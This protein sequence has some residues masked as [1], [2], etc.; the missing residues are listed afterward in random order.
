M[1][2]DNI[3]IHKDYVNSCWYLQTDEFG[4]I[5]IPF[6]S[7]CTDFIKQCY[8]VAK[9]VLDL[10]TYNYNIY[11]YVTKHLDTA[12][13]TYYRFTLHD[14][15][16]HNITEKLNINCQSAI[17]E[18]YVE[19]TDKLTYNPYRIELHKNTTPQYNYYALCF[20]SYRYW[21]KLYKHDDDVFDKLL[22]PTFRPCYLL[23]TTP[24][25][26]TAIHKVYS[27]LSELTAT[28]VKFIGSTNINKKP[29]ETYQI[30]HLLF[31]IPMDYHAA[32]ESKIINDYRVCKQCNHLFK[33]EHSKQ[34]FCKPCSSVPGFANSHRPER[35]LIEKRKYAIKRI[36][37]DIEEEYYQKDLPSFIDD[38]KKHLQEL[39]KKLKSE[40]LSEEDIK[41]IVQT[42]DTW[43]RGQL[44]N[45]YKIPEVHKQLLQQ[46]HNK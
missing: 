27:T 15:E 11:N 35:I 34:V 17:K 7:L 32:I 23:N 37:E 10:I 12:N 9:S 43:L 22:P 18:Q 46:E 40:K 39:N 36:K 14:L 16:L 3:K 24:N 25:T 13:T 5:T 28:Y 4:L 6:G 31:L 38:S 30:P 20:I 41:A 26:N 29:Y 19:I 42:Y 45:F 8:S 44:F 21:L 1:N 33:R 2:T